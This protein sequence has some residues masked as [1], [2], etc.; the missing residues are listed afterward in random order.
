MTNWIF[1]A[2]LAPAVFT[3][4]NFLDK[5]IV[6]S[7]V[8]DYRGV[9]IYSGIVGL[10]AGTFFWL[11]FGRPILP[12]FDGFIVI[13]VGMLT[14]W[15]FLFY[16]KALSSSQTSYVIGLF[17][18]IPVFT[19][20]FSFL[21]LHEVISTNQLFGF[22][23]IL[24]SAILLSYQKQKKKFKLDTSFYYILTADVF[25]AA[26]SVLIKFAINA[27]SFTKILCYESWGIAIGALFLFIF[28]KACRNAFLE[29]TK[30]VGNKVLGIMLLNEG[31]YILAKTI[32]LFAVSLGPVTL[33]SVLGGTQV[34]YG[35][36]FGV[37][38]TMLMP[39]VFNEGIAQKEIL[40]KLILMGGLFVGIWLMQ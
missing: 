22:F 21:F 11:I 9:P 38:L 4:V 14:V 1:L 23:L 15:A 40:K 34:F 20:L 25:F 5:Y 8:K 10:I 6:E 29:T 7:K 3:V 26:S 33:V 28:Y 37:I 30:T 17:Q 31:I 32:T 2:L 12:F 36:L 27:N 13:T 16:F 39:K 35:I 18:L 19:L 24:I